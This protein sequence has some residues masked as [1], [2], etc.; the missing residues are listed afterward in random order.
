MQVV[1]QIK[2]I[3]GKNLKENVG[4]VHDYLEMTFDCSFDKEV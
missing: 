2:G 3:Y 4:T 1:Q